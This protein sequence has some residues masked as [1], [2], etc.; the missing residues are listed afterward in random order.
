MKIFKITFLLFLACG[1]MAQSVSLNVGGTISD[2]TKVTMRDALVSCTKNGKP[3]TSF[4]TSFNGTYFLYLPMGAEYVVTVS[5]N[6]YAKKY[7]TVSTLGVSEESAKKKFSVMIT[8]LELIESVPGVDYALFNQ[9]MNKYY[10]NPKID[11]FEYDKKYLKDMLAQ[12]EE[13]KIAKKEAIL[14]AK[15]KAEQDKKNADLALQK[16]MNAERLAI[17]TASLKNLEKEIE[18]AKKLQT[19]KVNV[20]PATLSSPKILVA[21]ALLVKTNPN[22]RVV[23][24]LAKYKAGVTEEIIYGVNVIILQRILVRDQMA[25]VYQKKMFNWGG[26]ACFRDGQPITESTFENETKLS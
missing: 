2:E 16:N 12:V 8:D 22:D 15:L 26:V 6:G 18:A 24:L 4:L 25:W 7:F 21:D 23:A 3:F 11:N 20:N 10:Y 9:P 5:K 19:E 14:L 17:E 1:S 13:L